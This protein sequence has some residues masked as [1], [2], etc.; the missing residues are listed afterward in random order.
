MRFQ[1]LEFGHLQISGNGLNTRH[2]PDADSSFVQTDVS[3][4]RPR[5]IPNISLHVGLCGRR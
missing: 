2:V 3:V 4:S 1:R 5:A